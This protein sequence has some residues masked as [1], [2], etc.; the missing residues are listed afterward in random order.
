[1]S[2]IVLTGGG[3]LG[4]VTP[5]LALA[6]RWR[7]HDRAV[8]FIWIGTSAGPERAVVAAAHIEFFSVSSGKLPRYFSKKMLTAPFETIYGIVQSVRLLSRIKPDMVISA[9]SFV[10]VPVVLAAYLK[11]IPIA[12]HQQDKRRGLANKIIWPLAALRTSVW[13]EPRAK[14][15][16]NFVRTKIVSADGEKFIKRH[17]MKADQ[18][19]IVIIGG[20]TGAVELNRAIVTALPDLT[21]LGFVVHITGIGK[22]LPVSSKNYLQMAFANEEM[23]EILASA[24]VVI[25][26][27]GMGTLSELAQLKKAAIIVPIPSSHQEDNADELAKH[28]AAIVI[29]G[30]PRAEMIIKKVEEL[31]VDAVT[32]RQIGEALSKLIPEASDEFIRMAMN[33][34]KQKNAQ[35]E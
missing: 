4:S 28:R 14:T 17:N 1:M 20:G 31:L 10:G 5:L 35:Y 26:R 29:K 11:K 7:K 22:T 6:E 21:S 25:S 8:K 27:A 16:G 12:I 3:T 19:I 34:L 2:L 32:R 18:S 30:H 33:F 24:S 23:G 9:G 15:I 13:S